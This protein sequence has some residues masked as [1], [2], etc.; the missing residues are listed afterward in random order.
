MR[1]KGLLFL[2]LPALAVVVSA[3]AQTPALKA[4]S[5]FHIDLPKDS[6]V[7]V[8]SV[9][10]GQSRA[11]ARGGAMMLDLRTLLTL[12]NSGSQ[13]IRGAALLVTAQEV[14]PGGKASVIVPSLSV[15][16]G[17]TFPV[18]IDLRLLRPLAHGNGPLV[19]VTLDGVLFD[20]L[21]FYGPNRLNSRRVMTQWELEAR[22]DRRYFLS[23]LESEGPEGLR[24][25]LLA[26]IARQSERPRIDVKFARSGRSTNTE[27]EREI[28]I[29]FVS[30]PDAPVEV[31]GG[32]ARVAGNEARAPVIEVQNKS[33]RIVRHLELGWLIRDRNGREFMGGSVPSDLV[34]GPGEHSQIAQK[35]ALRFSERSNSPVP[36]QS[37]TGFVASVEFADGHLWIPTRSE[38]AHP[39]LQRALAPSPEEQR[40]TELYR[41]KGLAAVVEELKRLR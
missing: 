22:R 16:P 35:A 5:N 18:R 37:M 21:T 4:G 29:A 28:K 26:S 39:R 12:R 17:E 40:L 11:E 31:L 20:D 8:V 13:Q 38:L 1:S 30:F 25:E 34:L 15:P 6:P 41:K 9:D 10:M 3:D 27:P 7:T 24:K 36:V 32:V 33:D 23:R 19:R 2:L 14:T